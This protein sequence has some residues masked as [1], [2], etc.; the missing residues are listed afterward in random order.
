MRPEPKLAPPPVA[1]AE[2]EG[3]VEETYELELLTPL[4]GGGAEPQVNDR[5]FPVRG[6]SIRGQLRFWWRATR[7]GQFKNR[8]ELQKAENALWGSTTEPSAV[9]I[10]IA[11]LQHSGPVHVN[12]PSF[13]KARREMPSI[14]PDIAPPYAAFPLMGS[15]G[16]IIP[17]YLLKAVR[18][19]LVVRYPG[20]LAA[21]VRAAMWAWTTLGGLGGRT[22]RGFG[23]VSV[24]AKQFPSPAA[25]LDQFTRGLEQHVVGTQG[26]KGLPTL[27][28]SQYRLGRTESSAH[29]CWSK[30]IGTYS[31]FRQ[32]RSAGKVPGRNAW[33]EPDAIRLQTGTM[34]AQGETISLIDKFPRAAFG[35]PVV[36]EFKNVSPRPPKTSLSGE[37][38]Q[39]VR[40]ASPLFIRPIRVGGGFAAL[41]LI[42]RNTFYSDSDLVPGGLRLLN[43]PQNPVVQHRLTADEAYNIRR[44]SKS[45]ALNDLEPD[46]LKS[47]LDYFAKR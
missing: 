31:R 33:P 17:R 43:A 39:V 13:P 32:A 6:G 29:G 9:V 26:L 11:N 10:R 24:R 36:F 21:E 23:A 35:L 30:A 22:R 25:W 37:E 45:A 20:Q 18:F 4:L 3:W 5:D 34:Q 12:P 8:D 41:A 42:M 1:R 19:D 15:V 7:G 40:L 47:F 14:N 38:G 27:H 16:K 46:V 2:R 28:R 44:N